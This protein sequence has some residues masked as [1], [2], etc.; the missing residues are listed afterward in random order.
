[1]IK[2]GTMV[3]TSPCFCDKRGVPCLRDKRKGGGGVGCRRERGW[4]L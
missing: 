1:M 3:S 2:G 4:G